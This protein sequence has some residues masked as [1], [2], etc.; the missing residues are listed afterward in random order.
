MQTEDMKTL[1][2]VK[3]ECMHKPHYIPAVQRWSYCNML[4]RLNI[5]L[6]SAT[7]SHLRKANATPV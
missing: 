6:L 1:N 5:I 4:K 2:E 7:D 3:D